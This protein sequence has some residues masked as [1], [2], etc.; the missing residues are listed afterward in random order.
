LLVVEHVKSVSQIAVDIA[1]ATHG[2]V[3]RIFFS[4]LQV[5]SP[6]PTVGVSFL[7]SNPL[8]IGLP[9]VRGLVVA[10]GEDGAFE[11]RRKS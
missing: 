10:N 5:D 1:L 11:A 6:S 2:C 8:L 3:S 4:V 9:V 7:L